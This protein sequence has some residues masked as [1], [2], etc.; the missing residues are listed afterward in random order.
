MLGCE[1]HVPYYGQKPGENVHAVFIKVDL[2]DGHSTYKS[3]YES[4][5]IDG[6]G[7]PYQ[8]VC[9][10]QQIDKKIVKAE[11]IIYYLDADEVVYN[12]YVYKCK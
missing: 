7:R 9:T 5:G 3:K 6:N 4:E 2:S 1:E 12:K 8:R 11:E 10:R